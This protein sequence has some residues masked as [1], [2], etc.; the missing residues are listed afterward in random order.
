MACTVDF[1]LA[2]SLNKIERA[3][4]R[5]CFF[6]IPSVTFDGGLFSSLRVFGGDDGG[7]TASNGEIACDSHSSRFTGLYQI[8]QNSVCHRFIKN[9]LVP[10]S[11]KV[12]LQSFQ[13]KATLI[14]HI[15][16]GNRGKVRHSRHRADR[17][18]LR[19]GMDNPK[20]S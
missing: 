6:Y 8:I 3:N 12:E 13:F 9:A 19:A 18:E 10:E 11:V 20:V 1:I 16:N 15:V 2:L 14:R 7:E 5:R 4:E 17:S